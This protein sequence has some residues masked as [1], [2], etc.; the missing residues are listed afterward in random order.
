[1]KRSKINNNTISQHFPNVVFVFVKDYNYMII[2]ITIVNKKKKRL[3]LIES[4]K[5]YE[6]EQL[7]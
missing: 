3:V 7:K 2:M 5:Q 4:R 6:T 1:M